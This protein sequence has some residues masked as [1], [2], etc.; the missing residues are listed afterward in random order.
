MSPVPKDPVRYE[1]W[2]NNM[3]R[4]RKG[5]R[6]SLKTQIAQLAA[7]TGVPKTQSH[8][9]NL[10]KSKS[11]KK[12]PPRTKEH[13]NN[14][15]ASLK[16]K[17]KSES[18][19]KHLSE[20]KLNLSEEAHENIKTAA[21]KRFE[22][23]EYCKHFKE[24]RMGKLQSEVTILKRIESHIGGFWYG[25]VRYPETKTYCEKW[26]PD[27]RERIRAAW[28][29]KSAISGATTDSKGRDLDCHHVYDQEKACCIWDEDKNGYYAMIN[30][31]TKRNQNT[32]RYD[33]KGDPNKF[34]PLTRSEHIMIRFDKLKWIKYFE[35]LID[36]RDGR[37]YLTKEEMS[38]YIPLHTVED[39]KVACLE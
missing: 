30:I 5:K 13:R 18:H 3:K 32:I 21:K 14:I 26:T 38:T 20:A 12:M 15:S 36:E 22:N 23:Q 37:C 35:E 28:D 31:G 4:S 25:N 39:N 27:L 6:P 34:V 33:I 9:D 24:S 16:N 11:G 7:V 2:I 29:Y 8:K 10:R 1:I 19:K 17:P